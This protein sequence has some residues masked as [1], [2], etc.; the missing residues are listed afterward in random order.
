MSLSAQGASSYCPDPEDCT[1]CNVIPANDINV[2]FLD[3]I[4][5]ASSLV[6][7]WDLMYHKA[8]ALTTELPHFH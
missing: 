6:R 7:T 4:F 3:T 1:F 5:N 8:S 2:A